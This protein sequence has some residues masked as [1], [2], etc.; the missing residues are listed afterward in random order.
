MLNPSYQNTKSIQLTLQQVPVEYHLNLYNSFLID[1][2]AAVV[3]T[4]DSHFMVSYR[5]EFPFDMLGKVVGNISTRPQLKC[6]SNC[7]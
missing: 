2:S 7:V 5:C 6:H 1:V 4:S 3:T